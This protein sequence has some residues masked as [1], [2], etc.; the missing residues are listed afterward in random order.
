MLDYS[1]VW[2]CDKVEFS[3]SLNYMVFFC[4]VAHLRFYMQFPRLE[5][6]ITVYHIYLLKIKNQNR[7]SNS[8]FFS[9]N[10]DRYNV[11][12]MLELYLLI[13]RFNTF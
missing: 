9:I 11:G 7:N 6:T 10:F 8:K 3:Q 4:E 1:H 13:P 12:F 2:P 5:H